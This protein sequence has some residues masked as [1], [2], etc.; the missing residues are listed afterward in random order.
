MRT[1]FAQYSSLSLLRRVVELWPYFF[2]AISVGGFAYIAV[3][4]MP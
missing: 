2:I 3:N 1:G 4:R